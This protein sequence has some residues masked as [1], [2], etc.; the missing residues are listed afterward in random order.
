MARGSGKLNFAI[1]LK[2][3]T[4]QFKKGADI[5]KK[6]LRSIQYQVLGMA[7]ALG[8]GTIGLSNLVREFV[9]VARETN[10]ARVALGNISDGAEG[11]KKNMDVLT[12]L[13]NKYGQEL[14]GVTISF[15]RFSA[16]AN[17]AGMGLCQG[18]Q[19]AQ[20]GI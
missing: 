8:L 17:A 5:V 9:N 4:S 15:A 3:T 18:T 16:A 6:S 14:N 13:A 19:L 7:S 12:N 2:M 20:A 11:F 1:A 10:R